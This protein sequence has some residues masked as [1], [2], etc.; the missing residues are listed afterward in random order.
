FRSA[1]LLPYVGGNGPAR[2]SCCGRTRTARQQVPTRQL[3]RTRTRRKTWTTEHSENGGQHQKSDA[4]Q[5][6]AITLLLLPVLFARFH[7]KPPH[8]RRP[9]EIRP[10]RVVCVQEGSTRPPIL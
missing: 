8:S 6:H 10:G 5:G 4:W 1:D 2:R 3:S 7:C 9:P